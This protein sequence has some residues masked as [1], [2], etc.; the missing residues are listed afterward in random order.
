MIQ[1]FNHLNKKYILIIIL[2]VIFFILNNKYTYIIIKNI[3]DLYI[4]D[5]LCS[6]N[7]YNHMLIPVIFLF[8]LYIRSSVPRYKII[9][10]INL[11]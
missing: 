4:N 5:F 3:V 10:F 1:L 8:F 7:K 11:Y 2:I 9:D 6:L